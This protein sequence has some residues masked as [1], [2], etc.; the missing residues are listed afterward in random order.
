MTIER[1]EPQFSGLG[2]AEAREDRLAR[3]ENSFRSENERFVKMTVF[4]GSKDY[5]FVC[6]CSLIDCVERVKLTRSE[7]QHIRAKGTRFFV[8]PGH[9]N[10]AVEEVVETESTYLVVEKDGHAGRVVHPGRSARRLLARAPLRCFYVTIAH[11]IARATYLMPKI[12]HTRQ[13]SASLVSSRKPFRAFGSDEGSN[14]SPS[15]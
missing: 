13:S 6:E 9:E 8:V 15:A 4:S 2:A 12:L 14:P 11:P 7:Y 3:N 1:T 10:V 5:E